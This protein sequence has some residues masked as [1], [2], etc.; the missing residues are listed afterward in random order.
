MLDLT[1]L[2]TSELSSLTKAMH[3]ARF[4]ELWDDPIVWL[5]PFVIDLHVAV[6]EEGRRRVIERG[7]VLE[8]ENL[9]KWL[10]CPNRA[11]YA[12]FRARMAEDEW[13]QDKVSNEG[14]GFVQWALRPF[15][16]DDETADSLIDYSNKLISN[17]SS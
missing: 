7:D 3:E 16:V 9:D 13:L 5:T 11:E 14:A 10:N 1:A 8:L 15:V 6:T 4:P 12:I 17:R 2:S